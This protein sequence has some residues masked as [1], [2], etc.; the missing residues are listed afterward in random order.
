MKHVFPCGIVAT[1]NDA[2]GDEFLSGLTNQRN[3]EAENID[4]REQVADLKNCERRANML[5]AAL[6][7]KAGGSVDVSDYEEMRAYDL[8]VFRDEAAPG[9]V[10]KVRPRKDVP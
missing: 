3:P 10:L 6:V 7:Q 9:T 8:I 5:I 1:S 2:V 4:L